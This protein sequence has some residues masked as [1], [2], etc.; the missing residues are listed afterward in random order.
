M[1]DRWNPEPYIEVVSNEYQLSVKQIKSKSRLKKINEARQ[2]AMY[3]I[4]Q[5]TALTL[6]EIAKQFNRL[7][8][9]TVINAVNRIQT[10]I[11]NEPRFRELKNI[12]MARI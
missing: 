9:T 3:L 7:D 2:F 8:H 12:L 1:I 10:K 4:Q 5:N 11:D 6:S